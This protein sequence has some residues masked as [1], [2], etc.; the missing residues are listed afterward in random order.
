MPLCAFTELL[1]ILEIA[2]TCV[3]E[4][5]NATVLL[6]IL[7]IGMTPVNEARNATVCLQRNKG[8]IFVNEARTATVWAKKLVT[9]I[10]TRKN[11][12]EN[13]I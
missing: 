6:S 9:K 12:Y 4:V 10:C 2:M 1:L 8:A 3:N 11:G 13:V 5:R 7:Q